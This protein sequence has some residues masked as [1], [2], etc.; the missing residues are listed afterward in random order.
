[1]QGNVPTVVDPSAVNAVLHI[2]RQ[3]FLR[4]G[5]GHRCHGSDEVCAIGLAGCPHAARHLAPYGTEVA[6]RR[7]QAGQ[8]IHQL[9]QQPGESPPRALM[10]LSHG[11]PVALGLDDEI[12]GAVL[13]M[14]AA[15][16]QGVAACVHGVSGLNPTAVAA[17]GARD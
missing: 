6:Y 9:L 8:L 15:I 16:G 1:M 17:P 2:A 14:P 4:H 7:T 12:H 13:E 11:G 10:G 3:N 5:P